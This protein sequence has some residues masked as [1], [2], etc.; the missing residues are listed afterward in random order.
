SDRE[1]V[2]RYLAALSPAPSLISTTPDPH[3]SLHKMPSK[4]RPPSNAAFPV[5]QGNEGPS[6]TLGAEAFQAFERA[7]TGRR[8]QSVRRQRLTTVE[9]RDP[10]PLAWPQPP[11]SLAVLTARV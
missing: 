2:S 3:R 8:I 1:V 10:R 9:A 5:P 6:Q 11:L 4:I 7:Q